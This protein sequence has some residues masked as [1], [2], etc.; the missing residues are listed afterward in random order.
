MVR[1]A[2]QVVFA[3]VGEDVILNCSVNSQVSG[4]DVEEVT[5][6]KADGDGDVIVLLYQ[7]HELFPDSSHER[8]QGRVDFFPSEISKGNFSLKLMGVRREDNGEF[9]CEV[10]TKNNSARTIVV[11]QGIGNFNNFSSF[12]YFFSISLWL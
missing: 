9:V 11:L 1:E 7:E 12:I 2:D 8:Y 4:S 5:W 6:K 3:H 10:H